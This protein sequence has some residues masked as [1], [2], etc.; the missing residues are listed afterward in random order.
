MIKNW[1]DKTSSVI[2]N[3]DRKEISDSSIARGI[4]LSLETIADMAFVDKVNGEHNQLLFIN[5]YENFI[6]VLAMEKNIFLKHK[7]Q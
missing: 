5:S 4:Y 1:I 6:D 3:K 7:S 2:R